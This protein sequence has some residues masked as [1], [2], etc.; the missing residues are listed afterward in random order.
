MVVE[1]LLFIEHQGPDVP[2]L[3]YDIRV[4]LTAILAY[5]PGVEGLHHI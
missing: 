3:P 2:E 5:V 1:L 4:V